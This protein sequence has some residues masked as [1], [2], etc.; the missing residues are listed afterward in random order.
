MND[1]PPSPQDAAEA[2]T[3]SGVQPPAVSRSRRRLVRGG[4]AAPVLLGSLFS[5]PV[6][7]AGYIC[8]VS[9]HASGNASAH[10]M[11]IDCN[12]GDSPA[13]WLGRRHAWPELFVKGGLP[14]S[15]ATSQ[16]GPSAQGTLFNGLPVD[17]RTLAP[18]FYYSTSEGCAVGT[19][20]GDGFAPASLWQILNSPAHGGHGV[21]RAFPAGQGHDR[22][23]AEHR[24]LRKLS[25]QC[26]SRRHHVQRG[27]G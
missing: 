14:N 22:V 17:G 23:S 27:Q 5:K 20:S 25:G 2:A 7:G 10:L 18:T 24:Y 8:T 13:E 16:F 26:G 19:T 6:L 9:G 3:A 1:L 21:Q 11:G 12:V 4:A 15:S